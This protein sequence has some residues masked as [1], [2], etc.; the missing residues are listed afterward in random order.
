MLIGNTML[1]VE[2]DENQH[3][4]YD[5]QDEEI[6]YDDLYMVFS[7]KWIFVRFNPDAYKDYNGNRKNY[8]LKSRLPVLLQEIEKHIKR[9]EK[10]EN[11]EYLEIHKLYYDGHKD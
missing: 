1:A 5:K 7:G 6:R 3:S 11:K 9:I 8:K 10:D 4:S 2:V